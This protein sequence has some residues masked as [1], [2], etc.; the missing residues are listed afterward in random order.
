MNAS[1]L[2]R[3]CIFG[4]AGGLPGRRGKVQWKNGSFNWQITDEGGYKKQ[5]GKSADYATY[6]E[7]QEHDLAAISKAKE[8]QSKKIG[9]DELEELEENMDQ[10]GSEYG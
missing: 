9:V 10:S 1:P 4:N 7:I 6:D 5:E 3:S 2:L 8:A